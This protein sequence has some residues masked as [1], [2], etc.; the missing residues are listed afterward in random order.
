MNGEPNVTRSRGWLSFYFL[1]FALVL[2]A[3]AALGASAIGFLAS[4]KL[5]WLSI[6]L[7]AGAIV[8]AIAGTVLPRR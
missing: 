5:L 6:G 4:T 1:S 3:G 7:S 8:F 2:A